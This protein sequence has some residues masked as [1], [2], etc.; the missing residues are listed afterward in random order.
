M[1]RAQSADRKQRNKTDSHKQPFKQIHSTKR[2]RNERQSK[3]ECNN[4]KKHSIQIIRSKPFVF[5]KQ[6][7]CS[8][9]LCTDIQKTGGILRIVYNRIH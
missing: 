1:A 5:V 2:H 3:Q 4:V 7:L 9:K 8:Q 6:I